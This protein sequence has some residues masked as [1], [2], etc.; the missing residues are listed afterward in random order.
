MTVWVLF[1]IIFNIL[2]AVGLA[3]TFIR[4]KKR[5]ADDPRLSRGLQLLQS[6]ISVLEDL[7]D[8]VDTQFKQVSQLLQEKIT[9]VKRACEG[10]QEHVHQVE[11]SIQKS[12][13][14]A[15]IFQDRI[16]HEEILERK[17]T[18]KYIEAAKL[19]HS[20]VSA[21]EIS[22]RLSIPKQEAEFIV[23]VNKQE[24]RYNDSNTPAWAKPQ[25]DIVES[26]E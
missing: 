15:Q 26:P 6:K 5:S 13:E 20:G 1:Q 25:I 21:D 19:A 11:Q 18:I 24:L 7:S 16:P 10:A 8:R 23:S 14:V 9:E 12:N 2:L 3:L 4:Q 17:T 22:K